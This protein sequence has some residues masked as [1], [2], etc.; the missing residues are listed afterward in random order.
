MFSMANDRR[1]PWDVTANGLNPRQQTWWIGKK[2]RI[3]PYVAVAVVIGIGLGLLLPIGRQGP[4]APRAYPVPTLPD[5]RPDAGRELRDFRI[6]RA[7][8]PESEDPATQSRSQA[9][10]TAFGFCAGR[11]GTNCVI[12][13][14]TFIL[15]D[16]TIRLGLIDAPELG[17]PACEAERELAQRA[18]QRLHALLN[19]GAVSLETV[20]S[21]DRDRFGR[22]LRDAVVNGRSVSDALVAE[23]LA[24]PWQGRKEV[25]C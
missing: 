2:K 20:G 12:D 10:S 24:R 6:E 11:S 8:V 5:Q 7:Q 22:L 15:G 21:R 4:E 13:G 3:W 18:E 23:G 1:N 25:W 9:T 16:E 19:G 17:N 14:D